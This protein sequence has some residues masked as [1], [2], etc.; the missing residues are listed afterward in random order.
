MESKT[1]P[2]RRV[3][4]T[5]ASGYLGQHLLFRW[6]TQGLPD[7]KP[8]H[9]DAL[10]KSSQGLSQAVENIPSPKVTVS[11]RSCDLS[12]VQDV[13][14]LMKDGPWDY[15]IHTAAISSPRLCQQD[16]GR[17]MA[18]NVPK[19]FFQRLTPSTHILALSTD[20][21][22]DG[23]KE[24]MPGELYKESDPCHP[25]NVYGKSKLAMETFLSE[26][27]PPTSSTIVLR[28]SI[29]LGPKA[30]LVPAHDTFLHFCASRSQEPTTYFTNEF[31]SVVGLAHIA[32]VLDWCLVQEAVSTATSLPLGT[33]V[34]H[35]GGPQRVHR[36]EMAQA[37]MEYLE[38]GATTIST[39]VQPAL[40]TSELSPLD[41]SM[42]SS[43]LESL[44]GIV[45]EPQTLA[46]LVQET[47]GPQE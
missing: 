2:S 28:S 17:A 10:V 1:V 9:V 6:L 26:S 11:V 20:Q 7:G 47:L 27:R 13:E 39:V 41:I 33:H 40:Q 31:R 24:N 14:E 46:G 38:V 34:F 25:V 30:P 22:Y 45:H 16:P 15:C 21:V 4:L 19:E 42:D 8:T 36:Y 5:G 18:L 35:L 44:T 37:V 23:V 29:I 43:K 3:L 12:K 32:R